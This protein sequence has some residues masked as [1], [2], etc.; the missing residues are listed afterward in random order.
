MFCIYKNQLFSYLPSSFNILVV[1]TVKS[2]HRV[3]ELPPLKEKNK[4]CNPE[5]CNL[6]VRL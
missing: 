4:A 2:E 3:N 5:G 1:F 6:L